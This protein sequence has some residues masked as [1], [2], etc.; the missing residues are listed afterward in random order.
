[1]RHLGLVL[2]SLLACNGTTGATRPTSQLLDQHAEEFAQI[3]ERAQ[4]LELESGASRELSL[5]AF[6]VARLPVKICPVCKDTQPIR[7]VKDD[8]GVLWVRV[9]IL[10]LH[11]G[12]IHGFLHRSDPTYA[13]TPDAELVFEGIPFTL[14]ERSGPWQRFR[15]D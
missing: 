15:L 5:E 12:G 11:H 14:Q 1:M 7:V 9:D 10:D 6:D 8:A 4:G 13:A 3:I 2:A